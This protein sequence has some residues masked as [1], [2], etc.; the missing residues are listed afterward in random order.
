MKKLGVDN[1]SAPR[2]IVHGGVVVRQDGS[3][4]F[5]PAKVAKYRAAA[6][7]LLR[8]TGPIRLEELAAMDGKLRFLS[9]TRSLLRTTL[10]PLRACI[11][12]LRNRKAERPQWARTTGS[13][14][15]GVPEW[16]DD[17]AWGRLARTTVRR[18]M[19][20][21][22]ALRGSW[23]LP[24]W[25]A[26]LRA[27]RL[28]RSLCPVHV[29]TDASLTGAGAAWIGGGRRWGVTGEAVA[30]GST[31]IATLEAAAACAAL[32]YLW[33][34]DPRAHGSGYCLHVDNTLAVAWMRKGWCYRPREA[35]MIA[36]LRT[37][38]V[39]RGYWL[40]VVRVTTK[41]NCAADAL[42]RTPPRDPRWRAAA[43]SGARWWN[44]GQPEAD[45]PAWRT[46]PRSTR[47]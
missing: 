13:D 5:D 29:Y 21:V 47:W 39:A 30:G 9:N 34:T 40:E 25:D 2:A 18:A 33:R 22:W 26:T 46:R 10:A 45:R 36:A 24:V 37:E 32:R 6:D 14:E 1:K 31:D 44:A 28:D 23:S 27:R 8:I 38:A 42:S 43:E 3:M 19:R 20:Q 15:T 17:E 41:A 12:R 35:D 16:Q 4:S 7:D 11:W